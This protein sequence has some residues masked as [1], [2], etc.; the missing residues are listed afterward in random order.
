MCSILLMGLIAGLFYAGST[1]LVGFD[2]MPKPGAIRAMQA[3]NAHFRNWMFAAG[4]FGSLAMPAITVIIFSA[5]RRWLVARWV[6]AGLLS[7]LIGA[8]AITLVLSVP[9]NE[10]L[11]VL[12]GSRGNFTAVTEAYFDSWRFWNWVRMLASLLALG[13]LVVAFR[14]EGRQTD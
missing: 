10:S 7:Y 12:D 13:F 14:E 2:A 3:I 6:L 11:L 5:V 9:L 1:V 8:F 4:F